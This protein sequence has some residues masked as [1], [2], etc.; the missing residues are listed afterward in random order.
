[1]WQWHRWHVQARVYVYS[2]EVWRHRCTP[3]HT[4][5]CTPWQMIWDATASLAEK[6]RR[7]ALQVVGEGVSGQLRR[8][9]TFTQHTLWCRA[10][11]CKHSV[12]RKL[13]YMFVYMACFPLRSCL[14][15]VRIDGM[16]DRSDDWLR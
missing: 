7:S 16:G 9:T 3:L 12:K 10:C 14:L 1:M 6:R 4:V 8:V 2:R 5:R 15:G 11:V 13:L